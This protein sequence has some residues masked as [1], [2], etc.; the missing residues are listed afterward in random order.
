VLRQSIFLIF[1]I[2]ASDP[3]AEILPRV[4]RCIIAA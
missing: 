1:E 3:S 4:M 2:Y